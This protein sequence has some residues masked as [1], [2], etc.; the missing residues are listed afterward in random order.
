MGSLN[1]KALLYKALTRSRLCQ[2][3]FSFESAFNRQRA[4]PEDI[5]GQTAISEWASSICSNRVV[6]DLGSPRI[7]KSGYLCSFIQT[8]L[9]QGWEENHKY[10]IKCTSVL[11][12]LIFSFFVINGLNNSA[13]SINYWKFRTE[14]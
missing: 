9:S 5:S 14:P 6:P 4:L 13:G 3:S 7:K 10:W 2:L 8:A 1:T 11:V 12:I